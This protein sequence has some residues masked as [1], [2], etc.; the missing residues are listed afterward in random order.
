MVDQFKVG[1]IVQLRS[2]GPSMTVVNPRV[3]EGN[4][5]CFWFVGAE[6]LSA[7]FHPDSLQ[8]P[9]PEPKQSK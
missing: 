6:H 7:E 9:E 4:V 2:G 5:R 1:D 3:F 8:V